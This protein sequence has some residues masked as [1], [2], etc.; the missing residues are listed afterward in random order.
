MSRD[1]SKSDDLLYLNNG[2][3]QSG[4]NYNCTVRF[5]FKHSQHG[6]SHAA[7]RQVSMTNDFK[8]VRTGNASIT[9]KVFNAAT[10]ALLSEKQLTLTADRYSTISHVHDQMNDQFDVAVRAVDSNLSGTVDAVKTTYNGNDHYE[11]RT[12]FKMA[13]SAGTAYSFTLS[14]GATRL[15]AGTV[16]DLEAILG[17]SEF[18]TTKTPQNATVGLVSDGLYNVNHLRHVKVISDMGNGEHG[19]L[20]TIIHHSGNNVGETTIVQ[21]TAPIESAVRLRNR[22]VTHCRLMATDMFDVPHEGNG[23]LIVSVQMFREREIDTYGKRI[24]L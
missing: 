7:I 16:N 10:S 24:R 18:S 5:K 19:G 8:N 12:E 15:K 1:L 21:P 6:M 9:L 17:F 14:A 20:L 22:H 2:E 23:S 11:H 13:N 3:R 4:T